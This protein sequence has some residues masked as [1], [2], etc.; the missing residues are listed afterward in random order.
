M[1][2]AAKAASATT[3]VAAPGTS[4]RRSGAGGVRGA[5]RRTSQSPAS[6][7]G[8]LMKK[9]LRQ[10]REAMSRPPTTGPP[11]RA[12]LAPA[13]HCPMAL[14][15]RRGSVNVWLSRAS[16]QEPSSAAPMPC[17]ALAAMSAANIS[18]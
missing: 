17:T 2:A 18:V 13:A 16:E 8:P 6:P 15:R 5:Y 3:A 4:T 14:A 12:A 1:A 11:D 9:M 7:M 10:P